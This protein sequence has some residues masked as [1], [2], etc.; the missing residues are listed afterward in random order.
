MTFVYVTFEDLVPTSQRTRS[1]RKTNWLTLFREDESH[2]AYIN[3]LCEESEFL[4]L[5]NRWYRYLT[6]GHKCFEVYILD[7]V[8]RLVKPG[9]L[10]CRNGVQ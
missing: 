1:I 9:N 7:E 5:Y 2:T 8:K 4:Q 6:L 3:I 10:S